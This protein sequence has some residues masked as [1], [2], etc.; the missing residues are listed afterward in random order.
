VIDSRLRLTV[1]HK[2]DLT[3]ADYTEQA[4]D[5]GRDNFST[6]LNA[7][8]D[9]LYVGFYKPINNVYCE[10]ATA[11]TTVN[12]LTFEYYDGST[13]VLLTTARDLTKGLTRSGYITWDKPT[14][15]DDTVINSITKFWVRARP[16]VT[17]SATS[18]AGINLAFADDYDL[19]GEFPDVLTSGFIPAGEVSHIKTHGA[20]RNDIIQSLR[21]SGYLKTTATGYATITPWDLLDIYE[22]KQAA[23][24]LA[25]SKIFFNYSDEDKD[26]WAVKSRV[27][28][29]RY[30]ELMKLVTPSLDTD[31]DG[32]ADAS[33]R[34]V[35]RVS[36]MVR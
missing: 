31:D 4:A 34:R 17:H 35:S 5:F 30:K 33:E 12:T 8:D 22:L 2:D 20:V 32:T 24:N 25:L 14:D 29:L 21:N 1:L 11:N 27:Y 18:I 26:I 13:W 7:S 10:L 28:D 3:F 9:Y 15:W 36:R 23:I 19:Q 6:T 16:S